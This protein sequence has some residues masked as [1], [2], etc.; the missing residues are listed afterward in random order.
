MMWALKM[1]PLPKERWET[2]FDRRDI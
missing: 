2:A 1:K